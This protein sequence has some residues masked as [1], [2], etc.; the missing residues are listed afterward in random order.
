MSEQDHV[1]LLETLMEHPGPVIISGYDSDLYN[2]TLKG[3]HKN[4]IQS[5]AEY[6][7]GKSRT[8]VIWMNY[9]PTIEQMRIGG[10]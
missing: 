8:E 1:E 6:Y 10:I 7:A 4:Q 9:E 5:N 3:W 2:L